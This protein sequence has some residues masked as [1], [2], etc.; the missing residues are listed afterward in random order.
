MPTASRLPRSH[1]QAMRLPA[2]PEAVFPL[3]CPVR[4]A[5]WLR[6]WT[7]RILH[8]ESGV[9][10][11][12]CVFT[13]PGHGGPDW[14]WVVTRHDAPRA[15]QFLVLA[16]GSHVTQLDIALEPGP[17]GTRALWTYAL[18]ALDP[19]KDA[20]HRDYMAGTPGRIL[21]LEARLAHFLRTGSCL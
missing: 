9:A 7:A 2:P 19:G 16:P 14:I 3:L 10:E 12:G 5:E 11:P 8:S 13:T 6:G 4:E 17:D 15:V 20:A 21:D 1:T 18:T